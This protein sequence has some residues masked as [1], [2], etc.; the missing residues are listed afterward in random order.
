[1]E[2]AAEY[3]RKMA[4]ALCR[5]HTIAL[6]GA[7]HKPVRPSHGVM[8]YLLAAGFHV[9]PINPGLA[10]SELHGQPV[11]ARLAD[12][13]EPIDLV[14]IFRRRQALSGI[15]DEALGL[16]PQPAAIWMQFN[17]VDQPAAAR[18]EAAGLNVIMDRCTKIEHQRLCLPG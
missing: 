9:V 18:A 10:G 13:P 7:S 4:R 16:T 11:Y 2:S 6:V 1:M 8:A 3:D 14:N 12:I 17:L 15:V 5:A